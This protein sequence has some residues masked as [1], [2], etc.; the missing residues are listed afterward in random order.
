MP[1]SNEGPRSIHVLYFA[2]FRGSRGLGEE[3]VS[4][5]SATAGELYKE[6]CDLHKMYYDPATVRVA[7]NDEIAEWANPLA[8]GD[9]VVFLAPY[10]GG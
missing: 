6:L 3:T 5:S 7:V 4:T 9:T 1:Q 8:D 10:A 2:Q